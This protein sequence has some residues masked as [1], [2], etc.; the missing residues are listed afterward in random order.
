MSK[1]KSESSQQIEFV[2]WAKEVMGLEWLHAIPN[3]GYRHPRE[4]RKLKL[5]GAT[6]GVFDLFL[7]TKRSV[8]G[9][10]YIEF[11]KSTGKPSKRQIKF[12]NDIWEEGYMAVFCYSVKEAKEATLYYLE[13]C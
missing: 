2:K 8:Y 1:E 5:E 12:C 6:P 7:P 10:L 9:G 11:K 4:A 13:L 3:G